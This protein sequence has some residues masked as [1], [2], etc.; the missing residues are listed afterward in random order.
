MRLEGNDS[1][2]GKRRVVKSILGRVK[3]RFNA[4][5]SEVGGQDLYEVA[6]L[7]FTVCGPDPR[8]LNRV[9]DHITTFVE[10]NAEAELVD[11]RLELD[12]FFS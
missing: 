9:L 4:A 11:S 7:G 2:K 3:S 1:L 6:V 8:L 5:A 10:N 12:F